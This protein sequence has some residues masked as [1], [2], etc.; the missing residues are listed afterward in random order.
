[1]TLSPIEFARVAAIAIT[2]TV[3]TQIIY[4]TLGNLGL[5]PNR[6]LIWSV[7]VLAFLVLAIAGLAL[8]PA[9]PLIGGA[10]AAGGLLN[11]IQAG[12]GLVMFEPLGQ[13]GEALAPV[14]SAVLAMAFLLYFAGKVA[15]GIAALAA[16]AILWRDAQGATRIVGAVCALTG[17]AAMVANALAIGLDADLTFIAGGAGTAAALFLALALV[18]AMQDRE[19]EPA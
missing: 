18:P 8:L 2:A 9:R 12:M 15:I 17:I 11:T 1:M 14:F 13:A 5:E 3:A 16:G 7:E 6:Q 4:V 10:L 19:T